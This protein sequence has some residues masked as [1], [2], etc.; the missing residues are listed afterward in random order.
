LIGG[1]FG[2]GGEFESIESGAGVELDLSGESGIDDGF[3]AIDGDGG[4]GD[5]GSE[6]NFALWCGS[7]DFVLFV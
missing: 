4:F 5:V 1:G 6:D 2:D 3:D 7:E